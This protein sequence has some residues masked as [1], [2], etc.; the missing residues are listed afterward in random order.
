M[1]KYLNYWKI[2]GYGI[3]A[4]DISPSVI[5]KDRFLSFLREKFPDEEIEDNLE[6][7]EY[8]DWFA[9]GEYYDSFAQILC[10]CDDTGTLTWSCSCDG[11]CYVLYMPKYPWQIAEGDPK[12]LEE[13]QK[14]IIAA[15]QKICDLS[16]EE[17]IELMGDIN[18]LGCC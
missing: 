15:V 10:H 9:S 14:I 17:I 5:N 13:L 6:I 12:T 2:C 11:Y 4:T 3:N 18:E 7:D 16:E 1:A 8:L